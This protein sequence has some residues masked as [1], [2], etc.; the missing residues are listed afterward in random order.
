MPSAAI[1]QEVHRLC[2]VSDRLNSLAE[3]LSGSKARALSFWTMFRAKSLPSALQE[4]SGVPMAGAVST[5][6]RV[7][8]CPWL[9]DCR[10][11]AS[12]GPRWKLVVK[13]DI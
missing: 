5:L 11:C 3:H 1:L 13:N 12:G 6:L 9:S 7:M 10:A 2:A 8:I 4:N